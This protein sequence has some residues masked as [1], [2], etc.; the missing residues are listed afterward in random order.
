MKA[1]FAAAGFAALALVASNAAFALDEL[2]KKYSC[3][4]CHADD[5][6]MVGPAY[7]DVAKAYTDA[8]DPKYKGD[9][10]KAVAY[11]SEK[12][13]K[14]GSGVWG[15][16]PMPPNGAPTDAEIKK[17]VEA[18]LDMAKKAPAKK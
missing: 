14:G 16:V 5:K 1:R 3:T 8:K 12:V 11:L 15:P 13:R 4:A 18:V 10:A 6:K 9:R 17:M 7:M 2:H